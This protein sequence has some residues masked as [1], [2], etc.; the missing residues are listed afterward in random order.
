M[1]VILVLAIL[2]CAASAKANSQ[3]LV[4]VDGKRVVFPDQ[5]PYIDKND[6]TLVP[7]RFVSETLGADVGWNGKNRE[8]SVKHEA[9]EKDIKLWVNK[10]C[11]IL[12]GQNKTMDTSAVLTQKARVMVPL[13]FVSEGLGAVVK[14]QVVDGNGVVHNFTL[15]QSEEE[16]KD[17]M[18]K[19]K[20]EIEKEPNTE[21]ATKFVG[22]PCPETVDNNAKDQG[23]L[24]QYVKSKDELP[25]QTRD[26][27]VTNA[28]I[29]EP[30]NKV[31]VEYESKSKYND[32]PDRIG[33]LSDE[34]GTKRTMRQSGN[35]ANGKVTFKLYDPGLDALIWKPVPKYVKY[36]VVYG[37]NV[38]NTADALVAVPNSL[39]KG[40]QD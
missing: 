21:T 32:Y 7:V 11:Y 2:V 22:K 27:T 19:V 10:E 34:A 12:N 26:F 40:G 30:N 13:R 23:Y 31:V 4:Y 6:R 16:I 5:Q 29:D 1:S 3:I 39:Y 35:G 18:D 17:I 36:I 14:W 37:I 33:L 15:G 20:Q 38:E 24:I 25:I 8:V 9:K 28:Y